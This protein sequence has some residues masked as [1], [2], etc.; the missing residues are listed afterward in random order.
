MTTWAKFFSGVVLCFSLAGCYTS[1]QNL[2]Q[3][4]SFTQASIMQGG[5]GVAGIAG[6][7]KLT[8]AQSISLS[9][10][11]SSALSAKFGRIRVAPA[12]QFV[13][14]LGMPRYRSM[15]HYLKNTGVVRQ[16]D[17]ALI[18]KHILHLRYVVFARMIN[19][20]ITENTSNNYTPAQ[21]DSD[22]NVI[23]PATSETDASSTQSIRVFFMIYDL[24]QNRVVWSG[25]LDNSGDSINSCDHTA[26]SSGS[27][28]VVN[29]NSN[30]SSCAYPR[31]PSVYTVFSGLVPSFV[32]AV[33]T[34]ASH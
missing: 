3:D 6:A 15:L 26:V 4:P 17:L 20:G 27:T 30:N 16:S 33:P 2:Y 18:K 13:R 32:H 1:V 11:I 25:Y 7:G 23:S 14:A 24:Y 28:V 29:I 31:A 19:T 10:T 21:T 5:I 9:E 8:Q 34:K 12:G 22:G